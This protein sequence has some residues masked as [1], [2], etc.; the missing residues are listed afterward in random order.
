MSETM[1]TVSIVIPMRNE[2]HFIADC[3]DSVLAGDFPQDR[4]EIVVVDG[5]SDDQSQVIVEHYSRQHPFIKLLENPQRIQSAALNIGIREAKGEIIVRMDAHTI[6]APDYVS[7]CISILLRSGATNV[8][9]KQSPMGKNFSSQTI[10]ATVSSP[11]AAGDAKYRYGSE[12][13]WVDT[14]FLGCWRRADLMRLGGFREDCGVNEDYELNYRLRASGGTIL[15]SP[16]IKCTYFVRPSIMAV[17]RQYFK[18]GWSR[19]KTLNL[20][21]ASLRWRQMIPPM[22]VLGLFLSLIILP[23]KWQI[24]IIIPLLYVVANL[25]ASVHAAR[26]AGFKYIILL[27]LVFAAIHIGWGS[28]FWYGLRKYGLP[29]FTLFN[30]KGALKPA[31]N[32]PQEPR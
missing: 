14:V 26:Q 17:W 5:M 20:H 13:A 18:Y 22:F 4:L 32:V 2:E 6:Y 24:G 9:G 19:I 25:L 29:S 10:A 16:E 21:P 7:K 23:F 30:L 8:G 31:Q 3:L 11:F 12:E 27:P 28:G 1:P 15:Y